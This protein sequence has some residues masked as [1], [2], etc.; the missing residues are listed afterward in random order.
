MNDCIS[1]GCAAGGLPLTGEGRDGGLLFLRRWPPTGGSQKG[2]E[3]SSE[4]WGP[5]V[6]REG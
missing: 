4:G 5:A 2:Y 6:L 3:R 1:V